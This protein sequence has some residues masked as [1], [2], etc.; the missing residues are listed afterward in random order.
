[1]TYSLALFSQD[2]LIIATAIPTISDHFHDVTSIGWYGSAYM[3]SNCALTLLYGKCYALFDAKST[4]IGAV[5][6]FEIGSAVC[7]SAPTS[8]AFILGRVIAGVG[9]SGIVTGAVMIMVFSMPLAKRPLYQGLFGLVFGLAS[10]VGPLLGG[11]FTSGPTTW[12]WC[13]YINLPLAGVALAGIVFLLHVPPSIE[14]AAPLSL[15]QKIFQLD[16]IGTGAF[17]PGVVCLLLAL[18]WGGIVYPWSNGRIVALLVLAGV[19]LVVF[20]MVQVL[21]PDTATVPPRVFGQR[22]VYSVTF[23][24]LCTGAHQMTFGKSRLQL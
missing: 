7:G 11:A 3:L 15:R 18:Q 8:V 9:A 21:R 16:L 6:L 12:R 14:A 4:Y 2:R 24:S 23:V 13:F 17:V 20:V 10:A 1:M 22:S 19:L 5:L